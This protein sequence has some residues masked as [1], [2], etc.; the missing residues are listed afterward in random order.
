MVTLYAHRFV[1]AKQRKVSFSMTSDLRYEQSEWSNIE[2]MNELMVRNE[3][4]NYKKKTA[5]SS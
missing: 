2:I 3:T 4:V 5:N 1:Y